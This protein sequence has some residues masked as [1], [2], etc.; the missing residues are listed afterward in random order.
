MFKVEFAR[1]EYSQSLVFEIAPLL[2]K[3]YE[4]IAHFKDI[5]LSPDWSVY[6]RLWKAGDLRIFTARIDGR[7]V[8]YCCF[9]VRYNPHYSTSLQA[10]QDILFV[11]KAAR[12]GLW[13]YKFIKWCDIQLK[14]EGVQVVYQHVKAKQDF[15]VL[16]ERMGYQLQDKIY[17]RRLD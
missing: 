14:T 9:F 16:L 15:G 17:S 1:E 3:H 12:L 6:Q 10:V 11:D 4:E 8:G 13:P 7:L 2:L 5:A